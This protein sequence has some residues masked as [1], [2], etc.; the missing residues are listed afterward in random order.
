MVKN[1]Y[2]FR[3]FRTLFWLVPT[4]LSQQAVSGFKEHYGAF[5][6]K[7]ELKDNGSQTD[8]TYLS[9]KVETVNINEFR[10]STQS[11]FAGNMDKFGILGMRLIPLHIGSKNLSIDKQGRIELEEVFKAV[12][13]GFT[14]DLSVMKDS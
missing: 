14:L 5:I 7:I 10:P 4:L 6:T 1:V 11:D 8:V 3:L 12:C 13:N 9:G 2:R